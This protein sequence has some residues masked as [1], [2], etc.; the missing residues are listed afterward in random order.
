MTTVIEAPT[1][2]PAD[3]AAPPGRS[4][5]AR[6]LRGPDADPAWARPGLLA[7]LAATAVLYLWGLGASGWANAYYSAAVQAGTE[8]WKAF[9]FGSF[10]AAN[11][12]TVDKTP[13]SLW[14]M[15]LAARMFGVNAWSILVPQ[16]L[17]GVA[18][19]A[20]LYATVRRWSG[21]AAGLLAGAVL[22]STP[23][24]TLMFRFNNPD[25]LLVLLLVAAAYATARAVERASTTWL[26]LAG[27]AIGFGF[28]TK[29]LQALLVV[30]ALALAY[31][32][33]AP[34]TVRRRIG[35][36]LLAGLAVVVS[37]GWWVAI[38]ELMPAGSR[39]YIG[40]SQGNSVLELT[41]G[42]N[43]LGRLTGEETGSVGGGQGGG[44]GE[45]GW[46]R[47]VNAE[48]GGQ[49]GWLLPAALLLLVAAL[50]LTARAPRVDR[51]RAA[52][53]IW[54]G[55]L[56]TTALTFSFMAGIFHAY[57]NVALAPAIGAVVGI[58]AATLWRLR[59]HARAVVRIAATLIL[60]G[61][62]AATAAWS[63]TLLGRS[64]DW[65]PWLRV[66]VLAG[67]L[68]AAVALVLPAVSG[69]LPPLRWLARPAGALAVLALLAGPVAYSIQTAATA[70]TGSIPSAGPMVA[71]GGPGRGGFPGGRPRGAFPGGAPGAQGGNVQGGG[72]AQGGNGFPAGGGVPNAPGGGLAA[73]PDG[74]TGRPDGTG[75]PGG[76]GRGGAGGLLNASTPNA[77]LVATLTADAGS[78]T[79]MAAAVGA[80]SA[81]GYQLATGEPVMAIGGFNGSDP[82][83]TLAEFQRYVAEK[84]I[85][86]F[87][88]G[89][90]G[91]GMRQNGGSSYG[92]E[93]STWVSEN[94]TATTV[95]G[96][97]LY[98]LTS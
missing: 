93:I 7:L 86:Y 88:G 8:S 19:V 31:L 30:P 2:S 87:L 73:A 25:A 92:T 90:T 38:V 44:W 65:Y 70:H 18:S 63:W 5:P 43:G 66:A 35:Q 49:V 68:V 33:A 97:T 85:H 57:Y 55:W 77:E 1:V 34:T 48:N 29:M 79:W 96:V 61:A 69:K 17:A 72:N 4:R 11:A 36:L 81:A 16:A 13:A 71:G 14:P 47:L 22:A 59:T 54:G 67:G 9:F 46:L 6:F 58:G 20:L 52:L 94:F 51:T 74:G 3:P 27:T 26:L 15:A 24:A 40:G 32:L 60:A 37:A 10:D 83:P 21:P 82:S 84:K 64:A 41:L 56:V 45:T 28:L 53:V 62:V 12:I 23:V 80:N 78:Y 98:D 95:G 75:Q 76:M 42:Y 39:P 50:V 91:G 89:G